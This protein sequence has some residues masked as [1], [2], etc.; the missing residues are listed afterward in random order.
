MPVTIKDIARAAGVSHSTVSRALRNSPLVNADTARRI[1]ELAEEMGYRPS[2]VARSLVTRRTQTL[3]LVVTSISDPFVDQIVD[4]IEDAAAQ[5]GYSVFLC[6]SHADPERE[7]AVVETFHRRRVDAVIVLASRVGR[8]YG[9][10]LQQMQVPIVLINNQAEEPYL[11]SVSADD[12]QGAFL[13]TDYLLQLGHRRIAYVGSYFRPASSMRRLAGFKAAHAAHEVTADETLIFTPQTNVDMESGQRG[14][15]LALRGGATAVFCYNDRTAIGLMLAARAEG[16]R[17]PD[18]LSVVGFDDIEASQYVT[19][20]L[21]TVHQPRQE[22][23]RRA[24]QMAL[25]LLAQ[26]PVSDVWMP[27]ELVLRES[28]APPTR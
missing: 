7:I 25:A 8:L 14:L 10:R 9:E 22:M 15:A 27:C 3:G 2:A 28:A 24:V 12:E 18:E 17:I 19:P 20:P 23:G 5:A 4:G 21:T 6:S 16:I 26:Q 11:F 13:V 1:Q